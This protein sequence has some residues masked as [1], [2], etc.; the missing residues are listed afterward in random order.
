MGLPGPHPSTHTCCSACPSYSRI[1]ACSRS[2]SSPHCTTP[3][4]HPAGHK[5]HTETVR[6]LSSYPYYPLSNSQRYPSSPKE[7]EVWVFKN[8][9]HRPRCFYPNTSK[10]HG[11]ATD[12]DG[13]DGRYN[14]RHTRDWCT[15]PASEE[16]YSEDWKTSFAGSAVGTRPCESA[17]ASSQSSERDF[18]R[19]WCVDNDVIGELGMVVRL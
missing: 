4:S 14:T 19:C 1:P 17:T 5:T 10:H 9:I 13:V 12:T 3:R 11:T 18:M 6:R 2:F 16:D 7:K 8:T 15:R